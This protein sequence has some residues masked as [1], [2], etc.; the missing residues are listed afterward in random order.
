[1]SIH[2][3]KMNQQQKLEWLHAY[4]RQNPAKYVQKFGDVSPDEALKKVKP[5]FSFGNVL[6]VKVDVQEKEKVIV[7]PEFT[8]TPLAKTEPVE[9]AKPKRGRKPNV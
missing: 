6:G 9:E 1:M 2:V 7:T 3:S 5:T 8:E 4:K